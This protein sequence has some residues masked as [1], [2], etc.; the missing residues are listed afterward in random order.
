LAVSAGRG[1]F[2]LAVL[3]T[4]ISAGEIAIVTFFVVIQLAVAAGSRWFDS[5][6]FIATISTGKIAVV[7]FFVRV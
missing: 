7:T 1:W 5:A 2:D 3:I 4:A 6:I